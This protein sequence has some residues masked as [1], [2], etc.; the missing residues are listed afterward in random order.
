MTLLETR[1]RYGLAQAE[2][3]RI[4]GVP[5]RTY[6]RYERDEGHGDTLKREALISR[7]NEECEITEEKGLLTVDRI[8]DELCDLFAKEYK[9]KVRFCYLFGS[10][11]KGCPKP[12]SDVDIYVSSSLKGIAFLGLMERIHERLHKR[13]DVLRDSEPEGNWPL[14]YE[15]LR[16]GIK[17]YGK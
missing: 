9:G 17:L 1:K 14:T 12:K 16:D 8:R 2:A 15:I 3:A 5:L 11:A 4:L 6:R 13:V 7:L 10:Y